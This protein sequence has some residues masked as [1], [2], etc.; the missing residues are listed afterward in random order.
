MFGAGRGRPARWVGGQCLVIILLLVVLSSQS[1][2]KLTSSWI[3]TLAGWWPHTSL[4]L[5]FNQSQQLIATTDCYR[6]PMIPSILFPFF[7]LSFFL[8]SSYLLLICSWFALDCSCLH[9]AFSYQWTTTNA[10]P[11]FLRFFKNH[12]E[13]FY[14]KTGVMSYNE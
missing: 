5:L 14:N 13:I 6:L 10:V 11:H 12:F 7:F 8:S 1:T 9:I 4:S 2:V 3:N